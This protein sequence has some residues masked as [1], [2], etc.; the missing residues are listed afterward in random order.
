M[1][2][3]CDV[4]LHENPDGTTSC[5]ACGS[6]LSASLTQ[7]VNSNQQAGYH[8][9][10]GTI[11]TNSQNQNQYRI[12]KTLGEGGFG[13]TYKATYIKS[14]LPVAI[15]ENWPQGGRNGTQIIW[16]SSTTPQAKN[17]L[18]K[19]FIQEGQYIYQCQHDNIVKVYDWFFANDTA[20]IV[21][22]FLQG[23]SLEDLCKQ[24]GGS[25]PE[26]K[27]KKYFIQ[28]CQGL[29]LVH[30]NNLLH[31]D[32]KPDNIMVLDSSDDAVLIDFG[33]AREFIA[34]KTGDMTRI[35]TPGYAPP[36]QYSTKAR[37][38]PSLD[39]YALCAS[40]YKAVTGIEPPDAGIRMGSEQLTP[41]RQIV[42]SLDPVL[43]RL[44]LTGMKM[45]ATERFQSVDD[46][47]EGL[48]GNLTSVALKQARQ[49]VKE[50]KINEAEQE[51]QKC[52]NE[53]QDGTAAVELSMI[54]MYAND[55]RQAE[56]TAQQAIQLSPKDGRS[57]G[58]LG[59]IKCRQSHWQ[60]ALQYLQQGVRLSPHEAWMGLWQNGQMDRSRTSH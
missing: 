25:L 50:K 55:D 29:R 58:V 57:Y 47:I 9:P 40:M 60:E 34:G 51:Y 8:L 24:R 44:M 35:L 32:I 41:P 16:P 27:V 54:L 23:K 33:N 12:E 52:I 36:E 39:I 22:Q 2:V 15:K 1:A 17:Q 6:P 13:I 43:E 21:M 31:R 7:Q 19:K 5:E 45:K 38:N 30:Q 59:L 26:A 3:Q 11:L 42:P 37:R 49:L 4:C 18:L 48:K 10:S 56:Q 20:Y 46:I 53:E 14:S 28:I